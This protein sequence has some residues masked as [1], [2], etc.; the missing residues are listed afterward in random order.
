MDLVSWN[1]N[2][3]RARI[4][5]AQAFMGRHDPD[6]LLLQETKVEDGGFPRLAFL[7]RHIESYGQKTY[8]GVAILSRDRPD[9][10]MRGFNADPVPEQRRAMA[11]RFGDL[12]VYDLY[13]VNG[14]HPQDPAFLQKRAW[15]EALGDHLRSHHH[16]SDEVLLMGDFNITPADVDS[17]D[18]EG[19]AGSIHHTAE[20]RGWLG[21]LCDWGL[22]DLHRQTTQDQVFT[23]WDYRGRGFGQNHGLRIDLALGTAAVAKRLSGVTVDREE[24]KVGDHAEKPSDHAPLKVSLD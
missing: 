5:R 12:W 14:K 7:D 21:A 8:N 4:H 20:E 15:F 10:V 1:I 3:L 24:R 16:P 13:C 9:E 6:V 22:V 23:W 17:H 19:L 18:P 2:S 11:A